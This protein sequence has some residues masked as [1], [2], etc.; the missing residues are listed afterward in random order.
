MKNGRRSEVRH[1]DIPKL[2]TNIFQIQFVTRIYTSI[3]KQ[4]AGTTHITSELEPQS[5]FR[6]KKEKRRKI[7]DH[8]V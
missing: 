4:T 7:T 2:E 8:G 3:I 6:A 5:L 1:N